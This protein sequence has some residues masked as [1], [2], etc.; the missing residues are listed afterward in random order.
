MPPVETLPQQTSKVSLYKRA[1]IVIAG[2]VAL[3]ALIY[4]GYELYIYLLPR[5]TSDESIYRASLLEGK[6]GDLQDSLVL[7]IKKGVNDKDTKS[8]IY[9]ITHRYFDTGNIYEIYDYVEEHPELAFLK[10]AETIYPEL[11]DMIRQKKMPPMYN[12]DAMRVLLAYFETIDNHGYS[13]IAILTTAA[14]QYA[15]LAY[16][17][18][19]RGEEEPEYLDAD[20]EK[21]IQRN[22]DKSLYFMQKSEQEVSAIVDGTTDANSITDRDVLVG[23]NQYAASLRFLDLIDRSFPSQ[24]TATEIFEFSRKLSIEKVPDLMLYTHLLDASTLVLVSPT[25]T[26]QIDISL[27]PIYTYDTAADPVRENSVIDKLIKSKNFP[28][29]VTVKGQILYVP[30][31][32][33]YAKRNMILLAKASPKMKTWLLSNGWTEEDLK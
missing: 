14:N 29:W 1:L 31:Y 15:K 20:K 24:K 32:G 11:F 8:A 17:T 4:A 30:N 28:E 18:K 5:R 23:L 9:F 19:T 12:N 26:E 7:D 13:D 16:A 6:P 22:A 10:E 2:V 33:V 27:A 3:S 25:S 21:S